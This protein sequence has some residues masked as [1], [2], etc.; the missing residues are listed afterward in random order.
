MC[1]QF[2]VAVECPPEHSKQPKDRGGV[3]HLPNRWVSVEGSVIFTN[4]EM[5]V[6]S[7][8]VLFCSVLCPSRPA[9]ICKLIVTNRFQ[10]RRDRP[11]QRSISISS[12]YVRTYGDLSPHRFFQP[13]GRSRFVFP[14][15]IM[16][17]LPAS[18]RHCAWYGGG[19]NLAQRF[20]CDALRLS[21]Q[22][23]SCSAGSL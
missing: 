8:R 15:T 18:A 12:L 23:S 11:P 6:P 10:F 7:C 3:S 22:L 9:E 4:N 5:R 21:V 2:R 17:W 1:L 13:A 19:A 16:R 14:P 20:P